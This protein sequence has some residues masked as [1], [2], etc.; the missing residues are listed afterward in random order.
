[1]R[2]ASARDLA[3]LMERA[4]KRA[5]VPVA[6]SSGF[7]P[8]QRVSYAYPAPTGAAS[9]A[10]YM[11]VGLTAR[12]DPQAL[13]CQLDEVLPGLR[14][15]GADLTNDKHL[16]PQLQASQWRID[17][18][19]GGFDLVGAVNRFWAADRVVIQRRA[20]STTSDQDI[21]GAVVSLAAVGSLAQPALSAVLRQSDPLIRPT[22]LLAGLGLSGGLLTRQAQGGLAGRDVINL[23]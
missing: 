8:H 13:R 6:Y 4:L 7:S 23:V 16:A 15:E 19:A 17:W 2:F 9:L 18:P 10:E 21:K 11:L 5:A 3:R 14:I 20:K 12:A 1:L 22:D